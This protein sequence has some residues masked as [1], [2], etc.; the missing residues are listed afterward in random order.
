MMF[1]NNCENR[2][3]QTTLKKYSQQIFHYRI[4]FTYTLS[5]MFDIIKQVFENQ[6][7]V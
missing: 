2:V 1:I 6:T 4:V 7:S 5:I 3:T